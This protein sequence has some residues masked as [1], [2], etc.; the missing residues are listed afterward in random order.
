[1][2]VGKRCQSLPIQWVVE[3][4]GTDGLVENDLSGP[5]TESDCEASAVPKGYK[6]QMR[7]D[8]E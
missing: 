4:S 1:M 8:V 6:L 2:C 7:V 3:Q 5:P